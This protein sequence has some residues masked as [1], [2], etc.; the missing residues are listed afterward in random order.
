MRA[1][2]LFRVFLTFVVLL[3]VAMIV[4]AQDAAPKK[5]ID[6]SKQI[7]LSKMEGLGRQTMVKTPVYDTSVRR[8]ITREQEWYQI[9]V[10]YDTAPEWIDEIEFAYHVLA[11]TKIEG[12]EAFSLYRKTIKYIDIPKGKDHMSTAYLRPNT[13]KR[14]GEVVAVAVEISI[15][16]QVVVEKSAAA[17]SNIPEKWWKN[18]KVTESA[19]VTAR[20][21]YL[22]ARDETPFAFINVDDYEVIK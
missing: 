16:G 2:S 5:Q 12:R 6:W 21:G 18:P 17:L 8:T 7:R 22:L 13:V 4:E 20:G 1:A 19:A 10:Q 15:K 14:Y 11:K 9:W 3:F